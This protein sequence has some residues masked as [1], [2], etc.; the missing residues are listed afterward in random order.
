MDWSKVAKGTPITV[1]GGDP[2]NRDRMF[3]EYVVD[4]DHIRYTFKSLEGRGF[5]GRCLPDFVDLCGEI[6]FQ[7]GMS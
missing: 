2:N 7:E 1:F 5:I 4:S 6:I 3:L